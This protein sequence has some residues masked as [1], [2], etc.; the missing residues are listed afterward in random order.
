MNMVPK[1]SVVM[2]IYNAAAQI[3][4][5]LNSLVAQEFGDWELI[6][7][8]DAS[9]DGAGALMGQRAVHDPRLF[10]QRLPCNV[11]PAAARNVGLDA[12]R[13]EWV[14]VLDGDD[15]YD[16]GRLR[17]LLDRANRDQLDLIA[18]NLMLFDEAAGETLGPAFA[19]NGESY[20]LTVRRLVEND[21]PPRIT[22]L[23]QLKPFVR[24]AFLLA[25]GVRYP[26]DVR[27]GEDFQFLFHLL[28]H[29]PRALLVDYCG[30]RYTLPFS[31]SAGRQ[32]AGT[33]TSH[34]S[35]GL[36]D[37]IKGAACLIDH[38]S[39]QANVDRHLLKSLRKRQKALRGE[40]LWRRARVHVHASKF[41]AAAWLLARIDPGYCWEQAM[42]MFKGRKR[43]VQSMLR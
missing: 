12:A 1:I 2:A 29:T 34:G 35:D 11:G 16:S 5:A 26:E 30:Y 10:Y 31:P 33:R 28:E 21:R 4:G 41:L 20:P 24:R 19:L 6:V 18:D 22:V 3:D 14:T 9:T 36:S 13:G 32:A 39:K 38:A 25:T 40:A 43:R 7:V 17:I 23:G 37:L 42:G 27:V 15:R 8:D